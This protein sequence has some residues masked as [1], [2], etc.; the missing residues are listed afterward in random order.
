[1]YIFSEEKKQ[2]Y[3]YCCLGFLQ[4]ASS[5]TQS[6]PD[7]GNTHSFKYK[8]RGWVIWPDQ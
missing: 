4:F 5:C 3:A 8:S 2:Q 1:V 7:A 6:K